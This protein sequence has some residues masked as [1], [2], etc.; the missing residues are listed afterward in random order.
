MTEPISRCWCGKALIDGMVDDKGEWF[1][2]GFVNCP[3]HTC[4]YEKGDNIHFKKKPVIRRN[5]DDN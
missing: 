2:F 3:V 1:P 5:K 4:W